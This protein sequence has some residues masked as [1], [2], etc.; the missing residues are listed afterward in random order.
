M[1][2]HGSKRAVLGTPLGGEHGSA[3]PRTL[4]GASNPEKPAK[5]EAMKANFTSPK[6]DAGSADSAASGGVNQAHIGTPAEVPL[7]PDQTVIPDV[8]PQEQVPA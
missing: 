1:A 3:A 6:A 5:L 2:S 4:E 8:P 7:L